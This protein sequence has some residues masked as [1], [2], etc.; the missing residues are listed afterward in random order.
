MRIYSFRVW[1]ANRARVN[2]NCTTWNCATSATSSPSP[3]SFTS[4]GPQ[5]ASIF[6][7]LRSRKA[8]R[9][10]EDLLGYPL[11][12]R[13]SRSVALT[14]AGEALLDRTRR[15]LRN[16]ERDLDETRGIGR[17]EVGSLHVGFVGS[18]M[19]TTLPATFR[20]YRQPTRVWICTSTSLL[21]RASPKNSAPARSTPASSAI[22]IRRT[23]SK[24]R[25]STPSPTSPCFPRRT[26]AP[27]KRVFRLAA[28]VTTVRL[29]STSCRHTRL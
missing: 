25:H 19:L 11:F 15:T 7:N 24:Q 20:R 1:I 28:C 22:P 27:G 16:I 13:T 10:L 14:A 4:A 23:H 29:L 18:A 5:R 12:T 21:R 3:R 17:G 9:S 26:P 6:R 8:I 2:R